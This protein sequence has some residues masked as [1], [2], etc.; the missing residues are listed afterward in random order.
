MDFPI[1]E[2]MDKDACYEKL[3]DVLHP[4]GLSCPCAGAATPT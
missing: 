2:Y 4:D 3:V 1:A